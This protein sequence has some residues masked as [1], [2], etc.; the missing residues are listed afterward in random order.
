MLKQ[1]FYI[2]KNLEFI[3]IHPTHK[4]EVII[5]YPCRKSTWQPVHI[6]DETGRERD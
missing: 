2:F 4:E 1:E 3:S 6:L 5:G